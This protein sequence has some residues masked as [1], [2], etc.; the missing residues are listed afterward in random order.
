M[1]LKRDNIRQVYDT[2]ISRPKYM[3]IYVDIQAYCN[4]VLH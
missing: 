2:A 3:K 4:E 1:M